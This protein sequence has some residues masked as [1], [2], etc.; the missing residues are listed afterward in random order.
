[1]RPANARTND[2]FWRGRGYEP[3]EGVEVTFDWKD[4]GDSEETPK[5]LQV[6]QRAL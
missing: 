4:V 6:W 3:L 5:R 1:M 2:A